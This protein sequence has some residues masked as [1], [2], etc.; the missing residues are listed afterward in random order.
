MDEAVENAVNE[1]LS[2]RLGTS[3][4]KATFV[5]QLGSGKWVPDQEEIRDCCKSISVG[6]AYR[7]CSGINHCA[8]LFNADVVEVAKAIKKLIAERESN[9]N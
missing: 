8:H 9:A 3:R 1:W 6:M 7:H 4:P 2:R 5:E